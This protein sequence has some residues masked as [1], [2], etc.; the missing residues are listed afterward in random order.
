MTEESIKEMIHQ[1]ALFSKENIRPTAS[2]YDKTEAF[3]R[4][5]IQRLSNMGIFRIPFDKREGGLG[6]TLKDFLEIV[7]IVSK[8]CAATGSILLTHS[9]FGI[10]PIYQYGTE[11][12]KQSYLPLLLSG[13]CLGAF[14]LTEPRTGGDIEMMETTAVEHEDHWELTGEKNLISNAGE[15]GLYLT[16]SKVVL[17]NGEESYGIFILT[18]EMKGLSIGPLEEKMGIRALPVA[19]LLLDHINV[20]K[21]NI[22]GGSCGGSVQC[23]KV[24]D[25]NKLF[26]AAQAI[27]IAQGAFSRALD[28][29]GLDR[30]F[31]LRLIDLPNTQFKLAE[32]YTESEAASALLSQVLDQH[33]DDSLMIAMAKLKASE[34]AVQT[35]EVAIQVTG[36]Y[37][38]M[39]NNDIE[40]YVRDAKITAIYGG[41]SDTQKLMISHPWL[42]KQALKKV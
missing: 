39:R 1:A 22:L 7:R 8:D 41:T 28:Y 17:M 26:V 4:E 31:G 40:R 32:V 6:G 2:E 36:G 25:V 9:S 42:K 5:N 27:G 15:A 18:P 33:S 24:K 16:A 35:A 10:W 37:G 20:P 11:Q 21:Q 23:Q 19:P 29:V 34:V 12:Q 38:Y 14:A 30:Q 13:E 3:P